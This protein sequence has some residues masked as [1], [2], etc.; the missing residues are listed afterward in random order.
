MDGSVPA[1]TQW[2]WAIMEKFGNAI[3]EADGEAT[4]TIR[5][6]L[7]PPIDWVPGC[8]EPFSL[9]A[10]STLA[11]PKGWKHGREIFQIAKCNVKH[12]TISS[13]EATDRMWFWW[14]HIWKMANCD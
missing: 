1:D 13:I 10:R 6:E 3:D 2:W 5:S 11:N 4:F 8:P 7:T 14:C 9:P 12:V